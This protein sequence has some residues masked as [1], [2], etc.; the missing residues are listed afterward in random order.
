MLRKILLPVSSAI[1]LLSG[2]PSFAQ[3]QL[4][5]TL[6]PKEKF[7]V[8]LFLGHSNMTGRHRNPDK[9]VHPRVWK[10][11]LNFEPLLEWSPGIEPMCL[12]NHQNKSGRYGGPAVP[13]LK[14]L[15][16][17][18][19]DYWFGGIQYSGSGSDDFALE[20]KF[21]PGKEGYELVKEA[22]ATY[23]DKVTFAGVV[24]MIGQ[25]E[26]F[27]DWAETRPRFAENI[28]TMMDAFKEDLDA[29]NLPL[30]FTQFPLEASGKY[31]PDREEGQE[32]LAQSDLIPEM[33]SPFALIPSHDI[34]MLDG[35]HYSELG[36]QL[37][38][39]RAANLIRDNEFIP[40]SVGARQRQHAMSPVIS[41]IGSS[42]L[43]V[44]R[45]QSSKGVSEGVIVY[46]CFGRN[47]RSTRWNRGVS[48]G[49]Y[50]KAP[51]SK[52]RNK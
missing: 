28:K 51:E 2:I 12:D 31:S 21:I 25:I 17:R 20:P 30:L 26:V 5:D 4:G 13:L 41:T 1:V 8:F 45:N 7:F 11:P 16:E 40:G 47:V 9:E 23:K 18:Y 27:G 52:T 39:E 3:I 15:A 35:H 6:V 46:D 38:A 22:A 48:A 37:W 50:L 34:D 10:L 36:Y 33:V 14:L 19:P 49:I 24:T 43:T 32:I 44:I 42:R 29:P